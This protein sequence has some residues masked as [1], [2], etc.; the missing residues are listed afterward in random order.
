M[1]CEQS[2]WEYV[3]YQD[4]FLACFGLVPYSMNFHSPCACT[5]I[6]QNFSWK[7]FFAVVF[8]ITEHTQAVSLVAVDFHLRIVMKCYETEYETEPSLDC[9]WPR[10]VLSFWISS[11]AIHHIHLLEGGP[12]DAA[13]LDAACG[14]FANGMPRFGEAFAAVRWSCW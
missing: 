2:S 6:T 7:L 12:L 8:S 1:E 5:R 9:T 10:N 11:V 4:S 13:L 14:L 3:I